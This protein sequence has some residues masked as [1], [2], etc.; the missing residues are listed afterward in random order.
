MSRACQG[1]P[2]SASSARHQGSGRSQARP[3]AGQLPGRRARGA[4]FQVVDCRWHCDLATDRARAPSS[5][6][7]SS[8]T[9]LRA[10]GTP[11][12]ASATAPAP[13][14]SVSGT[15]GSAEARSCLALP[16]R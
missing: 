12:A 15:P 3:E 8:G 7:S 1:A 4:F 13:R 2:A 11:L 10:E 9:G 6:G 14:S 5:A 16:G